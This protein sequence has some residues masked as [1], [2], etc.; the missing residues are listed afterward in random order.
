MFFNLQSTVFVDAMESWDIGRFCS[1]VSG[2]VLPISPSTE[3]CSDVRDKQIFFNNASSLMHYLYR[4]KLK[5][6]FFEFGQNQE[7]ALSL[8]LFYTTFLFIF[9]P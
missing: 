7:A 1:L 2:I 5:F 8:K 4:L 6:T 3:I 9:I